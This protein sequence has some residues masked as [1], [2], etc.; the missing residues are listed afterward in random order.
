MFVTLK[1]TS[2]IRMLYAARKLSL[3]VLCS[4]LMACGGGSSATP[5]P[6]VEEPIIEE[7]V[8]EEPIIEEPVIE[9]PAV[10]EPD[11]EEPVTEEPNPL[12][13][14]ADSAR[15]GKIAGV[16]IWQLPNSPDGDRP[17]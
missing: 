8:M 14:Q 17:D 16:N 13:T 6:I 9:Q 10:E 15:A 3:I 12:S 2:L 4:A 1:L 7:P 5:E 11:V